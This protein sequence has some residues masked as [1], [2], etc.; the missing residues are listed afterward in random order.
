MA[1]EQTRNQADPATRTRLGQNRLLA[2]LG[3][4][5]FGVAASMARPKGAA[6]A[7]YPCH[8]ARDCNCCTAGGSCCVSGCSDYYD[9]CGAGTHCWS[10]NIDVGGG[11]HHLYSCCDYND[12]GGLCICSG[13]NGVYC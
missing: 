3:T 5:V 12:G 4:A 1:I 8:G 2:V 9:A 7:P 6:A 11:C 13:D 10:V